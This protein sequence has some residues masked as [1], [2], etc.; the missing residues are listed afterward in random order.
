MK[1]C[2]S[3]KWFIA[4]FGIPGLLFPGLVAS[5]VKSP[6]DQE[7]SFD[8]L[9]NLELRLKYDN[10]QPLIKFKEKDGKD[11]QIADCQNCRIS[12]SQESQNGT[13]FKVKKQDGVIN[14]DFRGDEG[15]RVLLTVLSP[16]KKPLAVD[17]KLLENIPLQIEGE[18]DLTIEA[19]L[20]PFRHTFYVDTWGGRSP[21]KKDLEKSWRLG[22]GT[23]DSHFIYFKR[24]YLKGP[25]I[26]EEDG[27]VEYIMS[28]GPGGEEKAKAPHIKIKNKKGKSQI[29]PLGGIKEV[30]IQ[31]VGGPP[32]IPPIPFRFSL[33]QTFDH[34]NKW[35]RIDIIPAN[36]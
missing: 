20:D 5:S 33:N 34:K 14:Y 35:S 22:K 10:T 4:L 24:G 21:A 7:A 9:Y 32:S 30:V 2:K 18:K 19:E 12:F 15:T 16:D 25:E 6:P 23:R 11:Y 17:G 26:L 36:Y 29:I 13:P 27:F 3:I 8:P 31:G 28:G 1:K